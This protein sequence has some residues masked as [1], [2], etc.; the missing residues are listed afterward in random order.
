MD[1]TDRALPRLVPW[2]RGPRAGAGPRPGA[3]RSAFFVEG[4]GRAKK[5]KKKKDI[6][7]PI[8]NSRSARTVEPAAPRVQTVERRGFGWVERSGQTW[9]LGGRLCS[10][11]RPSFTQPPAYLPSRLG[12]DGWTGSGRS[13]GVYVRLQPWNSPSD[14]GRQAF[15]QCKKLARVD[16]GTTSCRSS[17]SGKGG[18]GGGSARSRRAQAPELPA[19]PTRDSVCARRSSRRLRSLCDLRSA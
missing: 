5:R 16:G 14:S 11:R 6:R 1:R 2:I 13:A 8:G 3:G 19:R 18:I 7:R 15:V 17:R 9:A 12:P 10:S 4:E